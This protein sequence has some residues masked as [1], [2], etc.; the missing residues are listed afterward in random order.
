MREKVLNSSS[1]KDNTFAYGLS[2]YKLFWI[3]LIGS[4]FGVVVETLWCALI[5]HK[6]EIRW[7]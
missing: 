5:Q 2:F 6:F 1:C 7:G 3:F 4:F